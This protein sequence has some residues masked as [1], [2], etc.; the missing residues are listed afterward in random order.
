MAGQ[1]F[2]LVVDR[3]SNWLQIYGGKGDSNSSTLI[4]LLGELFHSFGIP[5]SLTSIGEP[6]YIPDDFNNFLKKL[7]IIQRISSVGFPHAN[8]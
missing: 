2:C 1:N 6:Q 7:G 3:F 4:P 8:Q 5:E